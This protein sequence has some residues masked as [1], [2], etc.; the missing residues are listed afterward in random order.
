MIDLLIIQPTPFCNIN[1]SYC[2]LPDR[3]NPNKISYDTINKIC[4]RVI[5]SK[6]I[7]RKLT[8]VWHAGEPL[9]V[10]ATYFRKILEILE[11]KFRGCCETITHAIQTNGTL[12]NQEWCDLIK[13]YS[14][15]IGVSIDGPEFL[16]D[17]SRKTRKGKGTYLD[18]VKGIDFLRTNGISYHAIA[19]ATSQT[20]DYA[21]EFFDFFYNNGFYHLGINIEEI[22][23]TNLSSAIQET[24]NKE[25]VYNFFEKIFNQYVLSDGHMLVR[26][27][28]NSMSAILRNPEISNIK[29]LEIHSHQ[30]EP[31][32]II[33]VD[34]KG[35]FSTF[36]PELIGQKSD[37][38]NNF[39]LGNV[40]SSSFLNP[41]R[42][43]V[44]KKL[45]SQ[46]NHG[47][48][49]CKKSCDFFH[50]CGGGAPANKYYENKSFASTGTIY[51]KYRIQ[52][53]IAISLDYL[54]R[55]LV[56]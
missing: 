27:F 28:D 34:Y 13:E 50:V 54:E 43:D 6:L 35:N 8:I 33:S 4:D 39:I 9:V 19:V 15:N 2:Y 56:N 53:P 3:N 11:D 31:Y 47:I 37:E 32:G 51:C 23:G 20:L 40:H 36:S 24:E 25:K 14:I 29:K 44:L 17:F 16:H 49:M 12:L 1:C 52:F 38:F 46:I 41:E 21:E 30:N 7:G 48:K 5:E 10:G 18:V 55:L 42:K 45:E 26:E 22:E